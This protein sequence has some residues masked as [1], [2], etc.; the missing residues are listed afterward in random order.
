VTPA[1]GGRPLTLELN[2]TVFHVGFY[3]VALALNSPSELPP[4]NVVKD[5]QGNVLAPGSL[6]LSDTAEYETTPV[7]PVLADHLFWHDT[8]DQS[9][10]QTDIV[11]P[12]VSCDECTLQVIEFMSNS[13]S[14]VGGGYFYHHCA[15]LKITADPALPAFAPAASNGGASNGGAAGAAIGDASSGAAGLQNSEAAP[16]SGSCAFSARRAPWS[17]FWFGPL[18]PLALTL[19]RRSPFAASM[20]RSSGFKQP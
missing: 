11:L 17:A 12:N 16:A 4:D 9:Q 15:N 1:Q 18:A 5:K 19:R 7:F 14:N 3:R 20:R 2:E 6:G 10:F 13:N 8:P